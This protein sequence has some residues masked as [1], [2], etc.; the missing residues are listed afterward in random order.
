[1]ESSIKSVL[2]YKSVNRSSEAKQKGNEATG[3]NSESSLAEN[4]D[5]GNL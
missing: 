1:M 4:C 5:F 2:S 3:T